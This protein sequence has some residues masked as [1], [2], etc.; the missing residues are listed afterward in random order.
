[1]SASQRATAGDVKAD[2]P[3]AFGDYE[4][5]A[6]FPFVVG[7]SVPL[8]DGPPP[9]DPAAD[10]R[11]LKPRDLKSLLTAC[12]EA[13]RPLIGILLR[14]YASLFL[15][16]F[17]AQL[18]ALHYESRLRV[19]ASTL[20]L[21]DLLARY[22]RLVPLG[23][24]PEHPQR[25]PYLDLCR[26]L[27]GYWSSTGRFAPTLIRSYVIAHVCAIVLCFVL[28]AAAGCITAWQLAAL[29]YFVAFTSSVLVNVAA[30]NAGVTSIT[31]LWARAQGALR[32]LALECGP[33]EPRTAIRDHDRVL[34]GFVDRGRLFR[35]KMFGLIVDFGLLRAL[36][37][38]AITI[39]VGLF[40]IFRG[41]GLRITLETFCPAG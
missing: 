9:P 18:L 32:A 11:A 38:T 23:A 14:A 1:M 27:S 16:D 10:L 22:R 41:A 33:G 21:D 3:A 26:T 8:A 17:A 31:E 35:A 36:A 39:A 28:N 6:L 19:R 12:K 2:E 15:G 30:Q 5:L 13:H 4:W 34:A 29:A 20:A 7:P 24:T 37:A 40:G 25:E